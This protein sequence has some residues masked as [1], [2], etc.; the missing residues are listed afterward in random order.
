[1]SKIA[2]N[3]RFLRQMKGLS[4][5][6]LADELR[7]TRSRVGGYEEARN[8]PP[9]D[10][11][12]RLSEYFHVAIDAMVRGDLKKNQSGRADE[13]WEKPYSVSYFIRQ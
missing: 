2:S 7:I 10:I 12:I 13:A 9:I 3:I 5:E 1:M 6:Q 8:E 4:Q 11:L